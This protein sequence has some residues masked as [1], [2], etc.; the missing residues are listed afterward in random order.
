MSGFD[1]KKARAWLD[2]VETLSYEHRQALDVHLACCDDCREREQLWM[3]LQTAAREAPLP[4]LEPMVE[5]RLLTG[6]AP[7]LRRPVEGSGRPW[8]AAAA[9][10]TV[11]GATAAWLVFQIVVPARH[12]PLGTTPAMDRE[13]AQTAHEDLTVPR[14]L[15]CAAPG[16]ALWL[17]DAAVVVEEHNHRDSAHFHLDRGLVVA[18]VG[19]NAPGYRFVVQTP[20]V[21]VEAHGTIFSVEVL[22]D[23]REIVRVT[24]G[25]VE[26][27]DILTREVVGQ[28]HAGQELVVGDPQ[29]EVVLWTALAQDLSLLNLPAPARDDGLDADADAAAHALVA[30]LGAQQA[31]QRPTPAIPAAVADSG[32]SDDNLALLTSLA[33]AHQRAGEYES[34][35]RVYQRLMDSHPDSS[36]ARDSLVTL[37]QIELSALGEPAHALDRFDAYITMA[38]QGVLAEEARI[39]RVRALAQQDRTQEVIREA[40]AFLQIHPGSTATAEVM[41]LRGDA[42]L[43]AGEPATAAL[44][45]EALLL[46]WPTSPQADLAENGLTACAGR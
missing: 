30:E 4:A 46:Q 20:T 15:T 40:T 24:E 3:G 7:A 36:A 11:C 29:P 34:A 45:Y 33:Q 44:D 12:V 26:V 19:A 32:S 28:V 1:C 42:H 2:G 8:L 6:K 41:R 18:E 35:C 43:Q 16:T 25:L 13:L 9:L 31:L 37:G 14:A 38:P 17:E 22:T 5:R 27:T 23:G 10:A 39:G 21:F